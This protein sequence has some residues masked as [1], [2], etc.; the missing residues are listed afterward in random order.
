MPTLSPTSPLTGR[1]LLSIDQLSRDEL[2]ALLD[3]ADQLKLLQAD[4]LPHRLLPGR[5][6]A[7]IFQK[8]S[9]R[10]RVSFEVGIT[11]LGGTAV[12]L[13]AAEMQ[14]GRGESIEDTGI[15]L[16]RYVDAIMIRARSHAEVERLADAATVP[17]INGLTDLH[18]PCQALAD[19][20][21]LRERLGDLDDR[22]LAWVGDG[23]NNVCHSL[24]T[25][26]GMMG[27]R[28]TVATPLGYEPDPQVVAAA[29]DVTLVED[30]VEAVTGADAVV[31]DVWTSMG[32]EAEHE[33]RVAN[34]K[35]YRVDRQ[36]LDHAPPESI[37]LHCLPAHYGEEI[38]HEIL[39]G[40][41]SAAWDEA[42]NRLHAQ[43]AL[44]AMV[45]A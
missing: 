32:Q 16:S 7:M 9:T 22:S 12:N 40:E 10:T 3:L 39:H 43:K 37:V 13:S 31:T 34:L 28:I 44:L 29:G 30:P 5:T 33:Q 19:L 35:P 45:M 2:T 4:G 17:V 23:C 6:L 1:D 24:I 15:V 8:P 20:Q 14:L 25:A 21:T 41:R 11:Q 18:H 36:L 26:A 38:S 27:M 42:E